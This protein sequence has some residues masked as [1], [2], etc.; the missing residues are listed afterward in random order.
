M[1]TEGKSKQ[2]HQKKEDELDN[3]I[4]DID[5]DLNVERCFRNVMDLNKNPQP[6]HQNRPSHDMMNEVSL[7]LTET[8]DDEDD[9]EKEMDDVERYFEIGSQY[10]AGIEYNPGLDSEDGKIDNAGENEENSGGQTGV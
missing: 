4:E 1:E 10:S 8:D 7:Q 6:R 5:E 2:N 3:V 9:E